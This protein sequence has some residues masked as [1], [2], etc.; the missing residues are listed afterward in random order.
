[1]IVEGDTICIFGGGD[2]EGGFFDD[3][4][5]VPVARLLALL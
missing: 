5:T 2:N 1:M 3:V 4:F